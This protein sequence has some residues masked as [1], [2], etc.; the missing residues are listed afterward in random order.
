MPY[1]VRHSERR[2]VH[3]VTAWQKHVGVQ[4]RRRRARGSYMAQSEITLP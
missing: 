2:E 3:V 4:M 1:E